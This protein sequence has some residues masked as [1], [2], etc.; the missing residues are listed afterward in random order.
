M[1]INKTGFYLSVGESVLEYFFVGWFQ[2]YK[3]IAHLI[4][5]EILGNV[6]VLTFCLIIVYTDWRYVKIWLHFTYGLV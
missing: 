1:L 2:L 6:C 4:T 5:L 3:E